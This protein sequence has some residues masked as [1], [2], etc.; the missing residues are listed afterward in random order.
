[1]RSGSLVQEIYGEALLEGVEGEDSGRR[2]GVGLGRS[3]GYSEDHLHESLPCA[4]SDA[5]PLGPPSTWMFSN[6]NLSVLGDACPAW[7]L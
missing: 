5:E 3:W 7:T 4:V 2:G 6:R 1:M